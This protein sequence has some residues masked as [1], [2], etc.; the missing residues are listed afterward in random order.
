MIERILREARIV[1]ARLWFLTHG[2][3]SGKRPLLKGRGPY[4]DARGRITVIGARAVIYGFEARA[5][6]RSDDG[7]ILMI[8]D[9]LM[10]N[11]GSSIHAAL[12]VRIGHGLKLGPFA[13][14]ADTD[15]HETNPGNG[16]KS[17]PTIIGNEVWVCRGAIILPGVRV[18]DGAVI[19]AGAV[20]TSHV[21]PFTVV[22]GNPARVVKQLPPTTRRRL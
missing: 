20:V 15:S 8:G 18:G 6:I 14:I 21:P 19:A 10:M 9:R 17:H 7:A 12:E 2:L 22:A 1:K 13:S 11:S 16:V 5:H 4:I 3:K